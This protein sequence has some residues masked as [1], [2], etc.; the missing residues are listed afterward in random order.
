[1]KK[2]CFIST[3][4]V[5][6]KAFVLKT[7]EYLHQN[8]NYD[9]TFISSYD[10]SFENS[11]PNYIHYYP[12]DMKRGISLDGIKNI[13][14]MKNFFRKEKF[15]II[16]YSTPNASLYASIA[17]RL[18]KIKVRLYC[19]WGIRYVGFSGIKRKIFKII[20]KIIC[21]NSTWIE[22]DS[23]GNLHFSQS[24][25]LYNKTKSSVI[26]NGSANGV[27][28]SKFDISKAKLYKKEIIDK[29]KIKKSIVI[30]FVGRLERDKGVN[31]L[32]YAF[33]EL[34][35]KYDIKLLIVG[36]IDKP[37]TINTELWKWAQDSPNVIFTGSVNCTEKYYAAMDIFTLPSYREGFGTVVIEAEAMG[38]PVVVT[39]IPGPTDAMINNKTGLVVEKAD[40]ISLK[41]GFEKLIKDSDLRMKYSDNAVK[42]VNE[43]FDDK[44]LFKKILEDRDRLLK[45]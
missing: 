28:L 42:F 6:L 43:K 24:E 16:Q 7:A 30:G 26:W 39:N 20:E 27:D 45:G 34:E 31:E 41:K 37:D 11:L 10:S 29:Y 12:I 25:K 38:V 35:D 1:M 22:P 13:K 8:G 44:V 18:S 15:D 23:F 14:K 17:G 2:I 36:P 33:K 40:Y 5:T 19:Q 9:I 21:K 3:I 32:F 4:P